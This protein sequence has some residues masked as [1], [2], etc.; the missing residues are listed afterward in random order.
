MAD[1]S[2]AIR[3]SVKD[4]EL[5]RATLER[6]GKDG[7]AAIRKIDKAAKDA[8]S[9][10]GFS[11]LDQGVAKLRSSIVGLAAGLSVGAF[12]AFTRGAVDAAGGLGELAEQL[13]VSTD[14]LQ[15][16][17]YAAL[18]VGVRNEE[19]ET[20]LSQLTRRIGEARQGNDQMIEAFSRLGVKILDVNGRVRG[21]DAILADI[22]DGLAGMADPADRAAAAVELFGKSGQRLLP[23]LSQGSAALAAYDAAAR[24]AGSVWSESEIAAA[25]KFSDELVRLEA[26]A[27]KLAQSLVVNGGV[28]DGLNALMGYLTG[29]DIEGETG[30]ARAL[31]LARENAVALRAALLLLPG[32]GDG[33]A[34]SGA[35][36]GAGLSFGD[37]FN[38]NRLGA[39][40]RADIQAQRLHTQLTQQQIVGPDEA[41]RLLGDVYGTPASTAGVS[42]PVSQREIEA[43]RKAEEQIRKTTEALAQQAEQYGRLGEKRAVYDA[44]QQAGIKTTDEEIKA[45]RELVATH[46]EL[47]SAREKAIAQLATQAEQTYRASKADE[48]RTQAQREAEQQ[49]KRLSEEQKKAVAA[50]DDMV[51]GLQEEQRQLG[52][53]DRERFIRQKLL[54][55]EPKALKLAAD[56]AENYR[57]Q[58]AAEAGA[59]YDANKATEDA[60]KQRDEYLREAQKQAEAQRDLLLEPYR[61]AWR[62]IQQLGASAIEQ[63]FNGSLQSAKDFWNEFKNIALRA[64]AQIASAEITVAIQGVFGVTG[65]NGGGLSGFVSQIF[66]GGSSSPYAG[67]SNLPVNSS[68][69]GGGNIGSGLFGQGSIGSFLSRPIGSL[70]IG[71]EEFAQLGVAGLETPG[72]FLGSLSIGQGL[73]ALGGLAGGIYSL[74]QGNWIGGATGILGAGLSLI[75]GVGQ[76]L[77]PL[78]AIA[79]PLLGGLFGGAPEIP[80]KKAQLYTGAPGI[81]T[82]GSGTIYQG[83]DFTY[84]TPFGVLG[85]YGPGTNKRFDDPSGEAGDFLRAVVDIDRAVAELLTQPEIDRVAA[86]LQGRPG[87][88]VEWKKAFDNEGFDIVKDRLDVMLRTLYGGNV[89]TQGLS[90]IARGN[91]NIDEL[92]NRAGE[93]IQIA[94]AIKGLGLESTAAEKAIDG[95]NEQ[96]DELSRK[97]EQYGFSA[98]DLARIDAER[99]RQI[100]L[101]AGDFNQGVADALLGYDNAYALA[102]KQL[103]DSQDQRRKEA[104]YLIDQYEKGLIDTLVDI[105]ALEELF[106]KERVKLAEQYLAQ[107]GSSWQDFVDGLTF[108]P[109]SSKSNREQYE[110]ALAQYQDVRG[111]AQAA[112]AANDNLDP[113]LAAEFQREALAAL[114]WSRTYQASS[115]ATAELY[116]QILDL[117][118][119][120]GDVSVPGMATGGEVGPGLVRVGEHGAELIR[121][122]QPARV[123]NRDSSDRLLGG[124]GVGDLRSAFREIAV[125]LIRNDSDGYGAI[126]AEIRQLLQEFRAEARDRRLREPAPGA[127]RRRAGAA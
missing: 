4:A 98:A 72:G 111:R 59:L 36:F 101:V 89:A 74:T 84:T 52:L 85:Y 39:G 48:A 97:A 13:G 28:L 18:Q 40:L 16:Y 106:G 127:T 24:R 21:T 57:K 104:V 44:M 62:S 33:A 41:Q 56:A 105:N 90:G 19:L 124:G 107:L 38:P 54:E 108:G 11:L 83:T 45:A 123:Y 87:V 10:G 88:G 69:F 31:R 37:L 71:L 81:Q 14:K 79:G 34:S 114:Q 5:V 115:L 109:L 75:P 82:G 93:V 66:G 102:Q 117:A 91:E 68:G 23:L 73:G 63:M 96:F 50:L 49:Q 70:G 20:G 78:L 30:L 53:T 125:E 112:F 118:R 7:D 67:T 6:L 95:L 126:V 103:D 120:F 22:A 94:N 113:A 55:A 25:D 12:V 32:F 47:A 46:P 27:T 51:F 86:A 64:L 2:V 80:I 8:G 100:S 121:L 26:E 92:V 9:G 3:L 43:Q 76:V 99:R 122:F 1:K 77:G 35:K 110:L 29:K 17:Q 60:K 42:N 65:P 116:Q 58:I 15:V 61:E 119:E